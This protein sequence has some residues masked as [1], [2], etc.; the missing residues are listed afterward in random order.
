MRSFAEGFDDAGTRVHRLH[1]SPKAESCGI[2]CHSLVFFLL[3]L[4]FLIDLDIRG[5]DYILQTHGTQPPQHSEIR[6]WRGGG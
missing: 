2:G 3:Y 6:Q 4:S 5:S 1:A